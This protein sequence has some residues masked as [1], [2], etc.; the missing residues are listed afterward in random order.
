[1]SKLRIFLVDDHALVRDGLKMVINATNEFEVVGE[2]SDGQSALQEISRLNPDIVL[3]DAA[4]PGWSGAQATRQMR[5]TFPGLKVLGLSAHED[6]AY[7]RQFLDSGACGYVLK[8]AAAKDLLQALEAVGRGDKYVDPILAAQAV[9]DGNDHSNRDRM[10]DAKALSERE[11]K[12]MMLLAQGHSNKEIAKALGVSL[13]TVETYKSRSMSKLG[14]VGR[15]DVIRFAL[16]HGWLRDNP[17]E[18]VI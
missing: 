14:L 13:K 6:L 3:M 12:V 15:T 11:T 1:M 9:Q 10:A 2:A 16:K 18:D 5:Q 17:G 7:A 4:M 8:R